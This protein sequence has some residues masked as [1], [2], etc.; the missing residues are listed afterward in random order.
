MMGAL[1]FILCISTVSSLR[2]EEKKSNKTKSHDPVSGYLPS[3]DAF[4]GWLQQM[5]S[6]FADASKESKLHESPLND[7]FFYA[8]TQSGFYTNEVLPFPY[9]PF[10]MFP[11][12]SYT[13]AFSCWVYPSCFVPGGHFPM[14]CKKWC[15]PTGKEKREQAV[16]VPVFWNTQSGESWAD[17]LLAGCGEHAMPIL[18]QRPLFH[19]IF[20]ELHNNNVENVL[21]KVMLVRPKYHKV[22]GKI[23]ASFTEDFRCTGFENFPMSIFAARF[24]QKASHQTVCKKGHGEDIIVTKITDLDAKTGTKP[25]DCME[26]TIHEMQQDYQDAHLTETGRN[27]ALEAGRH[28]HF[29]QSKIMPSSSPTL[30]VVSPLRR[31]LE[32]ALASYRWVVPLREREGKKGYQEIDDG[33]T[34][35]EQ[36]YGWDNSPICPSKDI[37]VGWTSAMQELFRDAN[38]E[39]DTSNV[40]MDTIGYDWRFRGSK[41]LSVEP[42][43]K[44]EEGNWLTTTESVRT[45]IAAWNDF[46]LSKYALEEECEMVSNHELGIQ[47]HSAMVS[48]HKQTCADTTH[49]SDMAEKVGALMKSRMLQLLNC[50]TDSKAMVGDDSVFSVN[51]TMFINN[52]YFPSQGLVS[53]WYPTSLDFA[54]SRVHETTKQVSQMWKLANYPSRVIMVNHD[55]Y[56]ALIAGQNAV[57]YP[58]QFDECTDMAASARRNAK[59]CPCKL[60]STFA[61]TYE[62]HWPCQRIKSYVYPDISKLITPQ[63]DTNAQHQYDYKYSTGSFKEYWFS[64]QS[65]CPSQLYAWGPHTETY[66]PGVADS[67][68]FTGNYGADIT[69]YPTGGKN[70]YRARDKVMTPKS[71]KPGELGKRWVVGGDSFS[72]GVEDTLAGNSLQSSSRL[73]DPH[74][75]PLRGPYGEDLF[76]SDWSTNTNSGH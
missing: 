66:C 41:A 39:S 74:S 46:E 40:M 9:Y 2:I 25:K 68:D 42:R 38:M 37:Y 6:K 75:T 44:T 63:V 51:Q 19:L 73:V 50:F 59:T 16:S 5:T 52:E 31:A 26:A 70:I 48:Q 72:R 10:P 4:K 43:P 3:T 45:D 15:F 12:S 7:I 47:Q 76:A 35:L 60:H 67:G 36:L 17:I 20:D 55:A 58:G 32:T 56:T 69:G 54:R 62:L 28:L 57:S 64:F 30:L 49:R 1:H 8:N 18:E 21:W 14:A 53:S 65:G 11:G 29:A 71:Y 27:A 23:L 22:A 34:K 24:L 33:K 13:M 61:Q